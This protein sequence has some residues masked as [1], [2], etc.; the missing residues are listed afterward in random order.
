MSAVKSAFRVACSRLTLPATVVSAS[1]RTSG[2]E[3]AMMM[4]TA[5]SEAVS[6]SMRKSRMIGRSSRRSPETDETPLE[7]RLQVLDVFEANAEADRR[8]PRRPA[9]RGAVGR[10]VERHGEALVAAPGIAEA[11]Q[12]EPVEEGRDRRLGHRLED[13]A[14]EAR[15]AG[16]IA[17]P[18]RMARMIG[19]G[20]MDDPEDLGPRRQPARQRERLPLGFAQ[21]Q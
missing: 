11:E 17:P 14:E 20:G 13:D 5:S 12:L 10:A 21:P 8:S 18:D 4:A 16:E 3:R 1:T 19:Q 7:I 9:G 2:M 15:R 6:V